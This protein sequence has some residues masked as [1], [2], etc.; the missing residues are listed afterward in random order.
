M[1]LISFNTLIFSGLTEPP[2]KTFGGLF[3]NLPFIKLTV[4]KRSFDFGTIPVPIAQMG[5]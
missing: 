5:S 4:S 2:Y 1:L 3:L